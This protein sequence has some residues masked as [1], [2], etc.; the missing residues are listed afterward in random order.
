MHTVKKSIL[1]LLVA[2]IFVLICANYYKLK[3]MNST[4]YCANNIKP[5]VKDQKDNKS[6][7]KTEDNNA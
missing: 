2:Q 7:T 3:H 6:A 1:Y 5:T 4:I